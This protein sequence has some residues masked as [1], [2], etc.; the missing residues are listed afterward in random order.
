MTCPT[1][2]YT[3]QSMKAVFAGTF[4]PPT[5]GH[6]DI[7]RRA[8]P[9]FEELRVVVGLNLLKKTLFSLEER[10][11]MLEQL[12]AEESVANV[13][14]DSWEGLISEYARKN[15]CGVL[16]RSVRSMADIPYEQMMAAMNSRLGRPLETMIM[17][18]SPELS[19]ISSSAVR[20]LVVSWKRLP[21]GIVPP[22]VEK[23]LKKRY[24]PLLQD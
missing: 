1:G 7:I 13:V 2:G 3:F 11:K 14:L 18:S 12:I 10:M 8:S 6:V 5:W 22:L 17:F 23:E 24:G 4:D 15:S 16:L 20:E 21:H 9:V 19:D